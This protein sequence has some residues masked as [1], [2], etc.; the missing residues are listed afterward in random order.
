VKDGNPADAIDEAIEQ[1]H[2]SMLVAGVKRASHT[3]GPH[4]TAFALLARS[5]VP[6]MCVPPEPVPAVPAAQERET[7]T[8]QETR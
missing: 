2:P 8:P 7:Q 3:P 6:V 1:F 4:G 5:R